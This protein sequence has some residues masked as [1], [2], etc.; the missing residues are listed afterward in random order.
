MEASVNFTRTH[1]ASEARKAFSCAADALLEVK[2]TITSLKQSNFDVQASF[3]LQSVFERSSALVKKGLNEADESSI[4]KHLVMDEDIR[5]SLSSLGAGLFRGSRDLLTG[6]LISSFGV[7]K[8][9]KDSPEWNEA[10]SGLGQQS[11]IL[12]KELARSAWKSV[13]EVVRASMKP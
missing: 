4:L 10:I 7:S 9:L 2:Q 8:K 13:N 3:D 5:S 6:F 1:E 11:V 12:A